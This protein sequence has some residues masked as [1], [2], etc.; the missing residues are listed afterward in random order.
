M[1]REEEAKES[2]LEKENEVEKEEEA[3]ESELEKENEVEKKEGGKDLLWFHVED[4]AGR[5]PSFVWVTAT[6]GQR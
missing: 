3:T 4:F 1:E 2:E 6:A 5:R